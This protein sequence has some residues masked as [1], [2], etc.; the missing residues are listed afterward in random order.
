[1]K[2]KVGINTENKRKENTEDTEAAQLNIRSE[3]RV[4]EVSRWKLRSWRDREFL[5]T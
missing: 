1:M 3:S 4:R 5:R 2:Q